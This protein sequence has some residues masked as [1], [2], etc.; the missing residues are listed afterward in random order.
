MSGL[1]F[2][3]SWCPVLAVVMV[4]WAGG[5]QGSRDLNKAQLRLVA[6]R[7]KLDEC[8]SLVESLRSTDYVLDHTP[9]G[10]VQ[11]SR[12]L[13]K[14]QLRL[15]A[16]RLKLDECRSLVES[17][18][19]TDYVLDH[20]PDGHAEAS[21]LSCYRLLELWNRQRPVNSTFHQLLIRLQELGHRDLADDLSQAVYGDKVLAVKKDFL[22]DPFRRRSKLVKQS[23]S[24]PDSVDSRGR[25]PRPGVALETVTVVLAI[26]LTVVIGTFICHRLT[27]RCAITVPPR[28]QRGRRFRTVRAE[29]LQ[30]SAVQLLTEAI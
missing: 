7:L 19:S 2:F 8:R 6:D 12:D 28:Q 4:G 23:S 16:D 20:T 5:V 17:L 9:D 29:I 22:S 18:R 10:G 15:V 21:L 27:G 1:G 11:G 14:A 3:A 13:N 25:R 24:S 26:C 30:E